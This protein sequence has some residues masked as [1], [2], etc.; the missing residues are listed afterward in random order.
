MFS[1]S[2][3]VAFLYLFFVSSAF[4]AP[5]ND[6]GGSGGKGSNG[7]AAKGND[8]T[9]QCSTAI[10]TVTVTAA[11]GTASAAVT[12]AAASSAAGGNGA[13]NKG[14]NNA[15]NGGAA[16]NGAASASVSSAA[17]ASTSAAAA[18][19][20][21]AV[22]S[23]SSDPQTS[24]TLDPRVIATGFES[25]GQQTPTAGQVASLTSSNNFINYCLTVPN[26]P[27][28]NGQQIQTGSCNPAPIGVVA[29]TT[30]MPSAK[31]VFPTN[32]ATLKANTSFTVQMNINNLD[33]GNFVNPDT[34]FLAAPQ[35][36]N[37]QGD[38]IGHSH[39]VI[40]A[41]D[42]LT[43]TTPTNPTAFAFFVGLNAPAANGILTAN[44]TSGIPTGTYRMASI[45]T[46]ANHAPVIVAVAQHGSLDD[47]IYFTV[48]DDGQP[49][50]GNTVG[51]ATAAT[52]SP[53]ATGSTV[54]GPTAA[55]A[56]PAAA[57]V[58]GPTAASPSPAAAGK[59][60]A[61]NKGGNQKQKSRRIRRLRL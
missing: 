30:N 50:S 22:S 16:G 17:P 8:D 40:E 27:I 47:Q 29:A 2:V 37:T 25:N 38:I 39:I 1:K 36:V 45:N 60:A 26:L 10:Q 32:L 31:F 24:L 19:N 6:S 11:A 7:Q 55:S 28:T 46:N 33:T 53:A 5:A 59:G 13:A 52:A 48:T 21:P 61:G 3:L 12:A 43:S 15:G 41:I 49:A 34:N 51:G 20:P 35:A 58:G 14:G 42:S 23:N 56:S 57:G 4:A 18:S 9:A 44:V 54:G